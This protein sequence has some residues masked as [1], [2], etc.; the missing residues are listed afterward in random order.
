MISGSS[1]N[2]YRIKSVASDEYLYAADFYLDT[3]VYKL[4]RR[5]LTWR[6]KSTGP[7]IQPESWEKGGEKK[8]INEHKS[9]KIFE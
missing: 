6:D 8:F 1:S 5:V 7:S 9:D 4:R 3:D 2:V